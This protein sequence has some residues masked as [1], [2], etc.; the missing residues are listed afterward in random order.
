MKYLIHSQKST[1]INDKYNYV[2]SRKQ[3]EIRRVKLQN[4]C[5]T[6]QSGQSPKPHTVYVRSD[7]L[8]KIIRTK[9]CVELE[10][11]FQE[12]SNN[13][14][15]TLQETHDRGRYKQ[16]NPVQFDVVFQHFVQNLDIYFT[17]GPTTLYHAVVA[18]GGS[19]ASS[20]V[21]DTEIEA[22]TDLLMWIDYANARCLD[23]NYAA[24][25]GATGDNFKY[26]YP[27]VPSDGNLIFITQNSTTNN[28]EF[29]LANFGL[30]KGMRQETPNPSGWYLMDSV[31]TGNPTLDTT[32][33]LHHTVIM[34]ATASPST[35]ALF[36]CGECILG[37]EPTSGWFY[38]D[39][40]NT[41]QVLNTSWIPL[42]PYLI[43][44]S[45]ELTGAQNAPELHFRFEDLVTN[46][47]VDEVV[48]QG[49]STNGAVFTWTL[50]H[51][52]YWFTHVAG[53]FVMCNGLD[54]T[55]RDSMR[56]WLKSVYAG[57][58]TG[59][60]SSESTTDE[61]ANFYGEITPK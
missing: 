49:P 12:T 52:N 30:G 5:Y 21:P 57:E 48:A 17:D 26:I 23:Q 1:A 60:G 35:G 44:V 58:E 20:T 36:D 61:P 56:G 50:G 45:K 6:C 22:I 4:F 59:S 14:I 8:S 11:N 40:S 32:W 54:T 3:G 47:V 18:S 51:Q 10:E 39:N 13:I 33:Q 55:E 19:G 25:S 37:Y 16:Q 24:I 27:R 9:H 15:C 7:A 46:T 41:K 34:P 31:T 38:Y 2:F 42:R 28:Y 53:P 43:S 29:E